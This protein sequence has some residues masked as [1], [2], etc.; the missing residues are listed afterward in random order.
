MSPN[1]PRCRDCDARITFLGSPFTGNK[2]A[3]DATPVDGRDQAGLGYPVLSGRAYVVRELA[4]LLMVQR[5]C[6]EVEALEEVRDMPHY[7][8]HECAAGATTTSERSS[9]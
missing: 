8:L 3:F 4:E 6:T 1:L 7:R 2:R 9:G 5:E